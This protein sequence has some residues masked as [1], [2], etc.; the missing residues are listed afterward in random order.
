M[1]SKQRR[2]AIGTTC[3]VAAALVMGW[4]AGR[5]IPGQPHEPESNL[6]EIMAPDSQRP[7]ANV[8]EFKAGVTME[9]P[10]LLQGDAHEL[11][12]TDVASVPEE[13]TESAKKLGSWER[14][15]PS[16]NIAAVQSR[17][18]SARSIA[19]WDPSAR[20]GDVVL[21]DAKTVLATV[22]ITNTSDQ[23][24]AAWWRTL[25]TMTLWNDN[26]VNGDNTLGAGVRLD[27]S[28]LFVVN[29]NFPNEEGTNV[30]SLNPGE[31]KQITLP[32]LVTRNALVD[33]GAFESMAP[34]N[35]CIQTADYATATTYRL[36]L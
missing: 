29:N 26:L 1:H 9:L 5:Y 13:A 6:Q 28:A 25:P 31:T 10:Q 27:V 33:Q 12:D 24:F 16:L 2:I 4:F 15:L 11:S 17:V 34:S 7:A 22:A 35:F 19:D 30:L 20:T 23:P 18:V 21:D 14:T 8:E 36:Q 32:F 3:L